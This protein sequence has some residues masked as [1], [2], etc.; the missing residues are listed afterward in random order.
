VIEEFHE[1]QAVELLSRMSPDLATDLVGRLEVRTMKKFLKELP[2]R[3]RERVI[4]LLQFPEDSV[5]GVM[6]N[7]IVCF[8][9]RT[10]AS[11]ARE[12]L[13]VHSRNGD[14][15]SVIFVTESSES[16]VL[17]GT[18][19]IRSILDGDDRPLEDI[20]DPF[21]STLNPFDRASDAAYRLI[22]A[23]VPAMPVTDAD[24]FL[25]GAMTIDAAIGLTVPGDRL[26]SL[27][28]FA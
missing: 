9:R 1:D 13:K 6:V 14:L 3:Q 26:R 27:K 23:Q 2:H 15:I 4:K 16:A 11:T 19:A 5:G 20:M 24:G 7:N 10:A 17:V 22:G 28:V 18:V 25:L 21:V 12:K 8:G